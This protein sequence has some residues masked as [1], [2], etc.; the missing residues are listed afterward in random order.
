MST[1]GLI[2]AIGFLV[3]LWLQQRVIDKKEYEHQNQLSQQVKLL[4]EANKRYDDL[5]QSIKQRA[6]KAEPDKKPRK[7]QSFIRFR[8]AV[9]RE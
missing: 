5:K 1:L 2:F 6:E 4:E 7:I 9:E 8:D 3:M